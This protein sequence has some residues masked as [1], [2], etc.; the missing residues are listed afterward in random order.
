M[1]RNELFEKLKNA[2]GD[3]PTDEQLEIIGGVTDIYNKYEE[4]TKED[5]KKKYEDNDKEWRRKFTERFFAP[6]E[7]EKTEEKTEN[8][9]VTYNDLFKGV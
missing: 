9:S 2:F 7:P 3:E 5:W 6:V 8:P 4:Q 1:E